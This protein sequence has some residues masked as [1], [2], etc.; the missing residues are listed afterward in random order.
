MDLREYQVKAKEKL[1]KLKRLGFRNIL[2]QS[3]TGSGKT[4]IAISIIE[5]SISKGNRVFFMV[6]KRELV[7]QACEALDKAG[8]KYGVMASG[9]EM[10][11]EPLVQVVSI[12]TL[13][14][15]Y[16]KL[17]IKFPK[18][19][20]WDEC[21]HIVA[22]TWAALFN[23]FRASFHIGLTATPERKD[24]KGLKDF[25]QVL[26][27][28]ESI[29]KLTD[30]GY[31]VPSKI[32]VPK[33]VPDMKGIRKTGGDWNKGDMIERFDRVERKIVGNSVE[34]YKKYANGKRGIIFAY[35]VQN[36]K[37]TCK[38][39]REAG[40]SIEH[41]DSNT[42]E[43]ER[44]RIFSAFKQ[45]DIQLISNVEI[46]TEG[47]DVPDIEVIIMQRPTDSLTLFLQ[48]VGRGLRPCEGKIY[49]IILDHVNNTHYQRHGLPED[50]RGW[51][52]KGRKTRKVVEY[53]QLDVVSHYKE[54]PKCGATQPL[55]VTECQECDYA[56]PINTHLIKEEK[57][58]L[59]EL[60]KEKAK[61]NQIHFDKLE[62]SNL[63]TLE[64]FQIYAMRKGY[65]QGWANV[66]WQFSRYNPD[67]LIKHKGK[68]VAKQTSGLF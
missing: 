24:G 51:S 45:G 44:D 30:L 16:D 21:H 65:K 20:L 23:F 42:P 14:R 49:L 5:G 54:C 11:Q 50:D 9:Y 46:F 37:N 7:N 47:V 60:N 31:L 39:F 64:D 58:E 40:I 1:K 12:P 62:Q 41:I 8:I 22:V 36:S 26:I 33:Y 6:H 32:F 19:I 4:V 63:K 2:L 28:T 68:W 15:R 27:T 3:P 25:F 10:N 13:I 29:K 61:Q 52:L 48:M 59:E 66:R 34:M 56:F 43:K 67:R 57:G 55:Q 35:S 17:D 38:A 53:K 18:V